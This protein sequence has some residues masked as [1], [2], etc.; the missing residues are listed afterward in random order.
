MSGGGVA[1]SWQSGVSGLEKGEGHHNWV[2]PEGMCFTHSAWRTFELGFW[3]ISPSEPQICA[4]GP[5]YPGTV[6]RVPE[7]SSPPPSKRSG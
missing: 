5:V 2:D 3:R 1:G 7:P 6:L 4:Q